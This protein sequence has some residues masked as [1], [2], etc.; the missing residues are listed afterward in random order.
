MEIGDNP[1]LIAEILSLHLNP[2]NAN[3]ETVDRN[4]LKEV[5]YRHIK[6]LDEL[7]SSDDWKKIMGQID[8]TQDGRRRFSMKDIE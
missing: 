7:L 3:Q 2:K 5:E 1:N 8:G 4:E 6:K